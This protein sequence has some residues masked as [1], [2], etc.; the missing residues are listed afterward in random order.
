MSRR[1]IYVE[2][3]I[4]APMSALLT[5]TQQPD[6][7]ERW[8][9]R[10][11]NIDYLPRAEA[12]I[13]QRFRYSTRI[14]F[15]LAISGEGETVLERD[16]PDGSRSSGLR[17]SSAHP[18]SLIRQGSGYWKYIPTTDGVRFLTSYT[19]STR[20]GRAG[21]LLDRF[22]FRPLMGWATAWSFDRLRLW[23]ETGVNPALSMRVALV[24]GVARTGLAIIF[25]YQGLVP[26]LLG[27]N[28]NE[29]AMLRDAGIPGGS[30]HA[31]LNLVGVAE[32]LVALALVVAWHS[33]FL[34]SLCLAIAV[35]ATFVVVATSS[36]YLG[37]AFNPVTLNVGVAGLA[38][39]DL[40]T[41]AGL[42]SAARC[43]RR[44]EAAAR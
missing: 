5:H 7:H 30:L 38:L 15:G 25:V 43:R 19:Y 23:L 40:L 37:E 31:L 29:L 6:L 24:H 36:R 22:A 39:V 41:L 44:P 28:S 10:F 16:L 2:T 26:K 21:A 4:R 20:F 12:D 3:L 13:A 9:L 34:P 14:G 11:T 35:A 1:S 42:P 17:F 33:R 27:P 8:D 18:L 32:L